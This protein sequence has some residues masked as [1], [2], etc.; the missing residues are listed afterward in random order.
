MPAVV[1]GTVSSRQSQELPRYLLH[2]HPKHCHGEPDTR[3]EV[4]TYRIKMHAAVIMPVAGARYRIRISGPW[5]LCNLRRPQAWKAIEQPTLA[6]LVCL[7]SLCAGSRSQA[8]RA[9]LGRCFL[10][11]RQARCAFA[12]RRRQFCAHLF[13]AGRDRLG[14]APCAVRLVACCSIALP[15]GLL[16][17]RGV[18]KCLTYVLCT[19]LEY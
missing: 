6:P 9:L 15:L 5:P 10:W 17:R 4:P 8:L 11:N 12:R 16:V 13:A 19:V 2:H 1:E 14:G 18:R 7:D 3:P